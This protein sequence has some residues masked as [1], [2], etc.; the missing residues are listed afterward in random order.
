M[1][2]ARSHR[3][4]RRLL[5]KAKAA[6]SSC[7]DRHCVTRDN[8]RRLATT[9]QIAVVDEPESAMN[10][11]CD[12]AWERVCESWE[13]R[14]EEYVIPSRPQ[15]QVTSKGLL[16]QAD[17]TKDE[18]TRS[19]PLTI[20]FESSWIGNEHES[21]G[22][23]QQV[24]ST[25]ETGIVSSQSSDQG[26]SKGLHMQVESTVSLCNISSPMTNQLESQ[27]GLLR[28]VGSAEEACTVPAQSTFNSF[29]DRGPRQR[30]ES[31]EAWAMC[32]I[33]VPS[34][35]NHCM[36]GI[37]PKSGE[38]HSVNTVA[39][40]PR[41]PFGESHGTKFSDPMSGEIHSN[42][43]VASEPGL[44]SS[45]L[46]GAKFS[47][48]KS[49]EVH[50]ERRESQR[51]HRE[52]WESFGEL[53]EKA[54]REGVSFLEGSTVNVPLFTQQLQLL[55]E[56]GGFAQ[57]DADYLIEGITWGFDLGVDENK[58]RGKIV[59]KNYKSAFEN[60]QKVTNALA[61]RVNNGKTLK[62]GAFDGD[63]AK[64]P[65]EN[66]TVVP[67]GAV[68][69]KL[70]PDKVRPFSDHTKT[71]F[72][73]AAD[74][75]RVKHTLSAYEDVAREL[76]P[77]Y[78]MRIEDVDGAFPILPL[79]PRVWKY[80][81]VWWYDVNRPLEEQEKPNTLYVHVFADF[82]TS[83][84]PGIWDLF[85]RA[86]KLMA[87]RDGVLTLPMPH[88][89]DDNAIIGP[90]AD[91]V[92]RVGDEFTEYVERY[93]VSLKR[94]KSR[95]AD[96]QQLMLGFWWDSVERTRTLEPEK[97]EQY[98]KYLEEMA[99]RKW[100]RLNDLQVL[101]GRMYRASLTM[102]HGSRVYLSE[103]IAMT[104]GLKKPWHRRRM[105]KTAQEDILA[106]ISILNSNH[107]RGYFD[108][109]HLP[110]APALYTDAM[111]EPKKSA[112]GWCSECGAWDAG[113]YGS[114]TR[115]KPI[116]ELE[117]D[118]VRRAAQAIGHQWRGCRVPIHIDN[119]SFQ[120]SFKKGW[121]RARRLT[122]ILRD[123]HVLSV[124]YDCVFAPKWISTHDNIGADALSRQD[125]D[126]F[127]AWAQDF[128]PSALTRAS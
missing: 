27:E 76:M 20:Q 78:F 25:D 15:I 84:L 83:P 54:E 110:W 95:K 56:D 1:A 85:W 97:L 118:V 2:R 109:T 51:E 30:V 23:Q 67:M 4:R 21:E 50:S 58:L 29:E 86:L 88:H 125:F 60:K 81:Y 107:G 108:T 61:E 17:S 120:L 116:D 74:A 127:E 117:G 75:D 34:K 89:V 80:M 32:T 90:T 64:L 7:T 53:Q 123:L 49:G 114:K 124:R 9:S 87:K 113:M 28:Q 68:A 10:A 63:P 5:R 59:H 106:V 8:S 71:R 62:L 66:A 69:K 40:D 37:D 70:E 24:E 103:L 38:V 12:G 128:I 11:K 3:D 94:L 102:P 45:R 46:F 65:G 104:R 101:L 44:L 72:N 48:P 16:V 31:T 77:G 98:I 52:R 57:S 47:D 35:T 96:W 79:R 22:L 99:N 26:K 19:A 36:Q 105:T 121:S 92:D 41:P 13:E 100:V 93:G 73:G 42:H 33:H 18:C 43:T 112:W 122:A 111:Q 126:R 55:V 39:S 14:A 6:S 119:Q 115:R 91:E 82:G